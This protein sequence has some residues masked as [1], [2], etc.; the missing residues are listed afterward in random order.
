MEDTTAEFVASELVPTVTLRVIPRVTI[1]AKTDMG[2]VRENNEDKFEL[3]LTEQESLLASRGLVFLVCDGM[4]GHAAGQVASELAAKTFI[5]VYL[6][7]PAAEPTDAI[8]AAV[9]AA[10]RYV[11][12]VGRTV[13]GRKGMGT[14][15][16]GVILCQDVVYTVQVGDSRIYRLRDGQLDRLTVDHTF[17]E[18]NVRLGFMTAEEAAVHPHR[19]W[20]L[21]AVGADDIVVPDIGSHEAMVGDTYFIC[22]DGILNHVEDSVI[23]DFLRQKAPS[24]AAWGLV[25]QALLGGGSDNATAMVVRIDAFETPA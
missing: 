5:D 7:H 14:T 15:L 17:L 6:N 13:P 8:A 9:K 10:N 21:R 1:G 18:E 23:H 11:L 4:G 20:L 19:H 25:N 22:S 16:S 12:D 3:F 2:R 24:D